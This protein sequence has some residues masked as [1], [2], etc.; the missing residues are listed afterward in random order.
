MDRN[1]AGFFPVTG[2]GCADLGNEP[3][4]E[5]GAGFDG[6]S[7]DDEGIGIEG[8]DHLVKEEREGVRLCS[9][10]LAGEGIAFFGK[11]AHEAGGFAEI[12]EFGEVVIGIV[13]QVGRQQG[14]FDGGERADGFE[15]AGAAAV[16]GRAGFFETGNV[17]I[18]EQYVA[19]FAAE[20]VT[21]F[22]DL[23]VYDDAAAEAGADDGGDRGCLILCTEKNV[24]APESAGVAIVNIDNGQT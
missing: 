14:F 15:I 5:F 9:E 2:H 11:T 8:G 10:D 19:E 3:L 1:A 17:L 12:A 16:A 20:A 7:A 18:G 22:E 24:M 23:V 21:A 13:G 4:L 6:S